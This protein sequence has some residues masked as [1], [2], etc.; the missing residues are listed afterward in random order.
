MKPRGLRF[1]ALAGLVVLLVSSVVVATPSA[2]ARVRDEP[3]IQLV[4]RQCPPGMSASALDIDSCQPITTGFDVVII[5]IDGTQSD[6]S[7]VDATL[8]GTT[9]SWSVQPSDRETDSWGIKQ[10]ALPPG[11]TAYL[12]AGDSVEVR[13]GRSYDFRFT[14]TEDNPIRK[15]DLLVFSPGV[16]GVVIPPSATEAPP[17]EVPTQTPEPTTQPEV[18]TAAVATGTQPPMRTERVDVASADAM[19]N[20]ALGTVAQAEVLG[21]PAP[22]RMASTTNAMIVA[23]LDKGDRVTLLSGPTPSEGAFWYQVETDKKVVGWIEESYLSVPQQ[24]TLAAAPAAASVSDVDPVVSKKPDTFEAVAPADA[25][26]VPALVPGDRAV[27]IDPPLILRAGPSAN[28]DAIDK[29]ADGQGVRIESGPVSADGYSWYEVT[30]LPSEASTGYVAGEFLEAVEF[31]V[32]DQLFVS[33]GVVNLRSKPS[34][35]SDVVAKLPDGETGTVLAGPERADGYDWYQISFG[36]GAK[37]WAASDF[38]SLGSGTVSGSAESPSVAT[39]ANGALF[40]AGSRLVVVDPP[41]NLRSAP[42]TGN[43]VILQLEEGDAVTVI[44]FAQSDGSGDWYQVVADGQNGYVVGSFFKTAFVAGEQVVVA[45]GPIYLRGGA[46]DDA[47]ILVG[48][49]QGAVLTVLDT[50]PEAGD[51]YI[52]IQVVT[53]AGAKGYVATEFLEPVG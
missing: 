47:A 53:E 46:R 37:G 51:G 24:S 36:S 6:V 3:T 44:T 33:D 10:T 12:V 49:E 20:S 25:G 5:S 43:N 15:L 39:G 30:L 17:T 11:S 42:D 29:L 23:T 41:V 2:E 28:A 8:D 45:D 34:V 26:S 14:T 18:Q 31:V 32:G 52:W 38:V 16:D 9:F 40:S 4:A 7:L 27:V 19:P 48:I 35:T 50:M 21:G 1:L 22:L 13:S